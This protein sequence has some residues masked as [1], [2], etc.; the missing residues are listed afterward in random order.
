MGGC[1]GVQVLQD[2]TATPVQTHCSPVCNDQGFRCKVI[3][4]RRYATAPTAGS[5]QQDDI[6]PDV[7]HMEPSSKT[8][9]DVM[10]VRIG[11]N[12]TEK[13]LVVCKVKYRVFL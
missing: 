8:L 12:T 9:Q 4:L 10:R 7:A 3:C 6:T 13:K 2:I 1:R 11:M 5:S